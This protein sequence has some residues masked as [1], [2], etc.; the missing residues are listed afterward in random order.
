MGF[1]LNVAQRALI[2]SGR[3][4][5]ICHKFCGIKIELH[6]I[7]PKSERGLDTFENCIPL[8]FDCHAEVKAYN[9]KHP[10]GRKFTESELQSHRDNWYDIVKKTGGI[11]LLP[12]Y[13]AV[14]NCKYRAAA[15][16]ELYKL[17]TVATD[18]IRLLTHWLQPTDEKS[19]PEKKN[20]TALAYNALRDFFNNNK[21]YF[22][23]DICERMQSI[24]QIIYNSFSAFDIAQRGEGY[25]PDNTGLWQDAWNNVSKELPPLEQE[26]ED[27]FRNLLEADSSPSQQTEKSIDE[28]KFIR[29]VTIPDG[30]HIK[31]GEEFEKVWEI[32]NI[33]NVVWKNRFLKRE[34]TCEGL[35]LITSPDKVPIPTTYPRQTVQIKV[36]M[37]APTI[38]TTT[39][40]IWKM[41]DKHGAKYFPDKYKYGLT[42]TINVVDAT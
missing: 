31:V 42:I 33:G 27:K 35:G 39:T 3:C 38:P 37:R 36:P 8:C 34:G 18:R 41:V 4:C 9:P 2:S 17:L 40:C 29:D 20:E 11:L 25:Q 1:P 12:N 13:K 21:I 24:L 28:S 19:L 23:K 26:L 15:I 16:L 7:K 5:C 14:D 10:K 22:D 6:H 30:S 32:Q